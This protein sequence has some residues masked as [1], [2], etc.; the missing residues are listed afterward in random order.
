MFCVE[1]LIMT[2]RFVIGLLVASASGGLFGSVLQANVA[3]Q[4]ARS[5]SSGVYTADQ[6]KRGQAVYT[7]ECAKCHLDDLSGG[8]DA[9]A[10]AGADFVN[11]WKGKTVGDLFDE[12]KA[13]MPFD[14]PGRLT[15]EQYADIIAYVFS[16][17]KFPAGDKELE[18]DLAP[19]KQ[20]RIEAAQP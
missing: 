10:L 14:G 13:T 11:G 16:A 5:V 4:Q 15:P 19:L 1:L 9:P 17:N 18:H 3:R 20:I 2:N 12:V 7:T 6:A 8:R